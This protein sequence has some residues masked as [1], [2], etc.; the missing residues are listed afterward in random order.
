MQ[1]L[2]VQLNDMSR[3]L[4]QTVHSLSE[5]MTGEQ[6]QKMLQ[7]VE[8]LR[9]TLAEDFQRANAGGDS[10]MA[11][12]QARLKAL[13]A[14]LKGRQAQLQA[15]A[16]VTQKEAAGITQQAAAAQPAGNDAGGGKVGKEGS[17]VYYIMGNVQRPGVYTIASKELTLLQAV[18]AAGVQDGSPDDLYIK[19]VRNDNGRERVA[20]EGVLSQLMLT[21]E[22]VQANDVLSVGP[23]D[24]DQSH[25]TEIGVDMEKIA[26]LRAKGAGADDPQVATLQKRVD[27]VQ[28]MLAER[29]SKAVVTMDPKTGK[30]LSVHVEALKQ[31]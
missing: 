28:K 15:N 1:D 5:Q 9:A 21:G 7:T 31:P 12:L 19:A 24:E 11:A 17:Q 27:A 4:S 16:A 3:N 26:E 8:S 29:G 22:Q 10:E 18:A 2:R 23:V 20:F 6:R 13:D 14:E 30:L 25:A